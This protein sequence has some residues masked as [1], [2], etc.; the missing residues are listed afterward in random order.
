M[1]SDILGHYFV[2]NAHP[3]HTVIYL[4]AYILS[5]TKELLKSTAELLI[6]FF[7]FSCSLSNS[8]CTVEDLL[9]E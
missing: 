1:D 3:V 6:F 8:M 9:N 5:P 7:F 2:W 4:F